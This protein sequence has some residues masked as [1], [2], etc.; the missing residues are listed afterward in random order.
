M[1]KLILIAIAVIALTIGLVWI[2]DKFIPAKFKPILVVALW[3]LIAVLGYQTFMSIYEPI[4]FN[5]VK[6][7]RYAEVIDRMI[8]VREAQLAHRQVT[9]TYAP[10]FENLIKFIDSAQ[11]TITQRRD[12]TVL[13]EVKTKQYG[14]DFFKEITIIDTLDYVS[15]KDSLFKTSDRYKTMM[16][17]PNS[18][19]AKVEMKSG[20]IGEEGDVRIPV[21]EAK[22]L[23]SV[24][25][26]DQNQDL[27]KQENE[28][29]A[30]DGVNGDAIIVGSME[31]VN[32]SGNWPKTY[33]DSE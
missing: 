7:K 9:G 1:L 20:F 26:H 3:A 12:S 24:I 4:Q 25:L 21:F 17:V 11:F 22:V 19:G 29:V 5:K 31:E 33:G 2:I 23:K 8:D 28:V 6:K 16:N 32:T 30:V 10:N 13:D 14:V 18:N 15:V 27:I